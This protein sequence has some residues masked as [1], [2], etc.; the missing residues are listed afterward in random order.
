MVEM[1]RTVH[2]GRRYDM[3]KLLNRLCD[4]GVILVSIVLFKH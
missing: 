3:L 4:C 2:P 1:A